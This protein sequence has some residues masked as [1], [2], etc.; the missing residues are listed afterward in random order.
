MDLSSGPS[1]N[2]GAPRLT[3]RRTVVSA[4]RGGI[5]SGMIS[6]RTALGDRPAAY[7]APEGLI[8]RRE[9]APGERDSRRYSR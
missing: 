8:G 4:K 2:P 9:Q 1:N 3:K 7:H 5:K 6:N